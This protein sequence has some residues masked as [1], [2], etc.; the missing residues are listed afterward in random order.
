MLN[1]P[2]AGTYLK[3]DEKDFYVWSLMDGTHTIKQLVV[4]FFS[5][6]GT[7]AFGRVIDLVAQLRAASFLVDP[8]VNVYADV[9]RQCR[10][11]TV[12]YWGDRLWRSF[13]QKEMGFGGIDGI[14]TSLYRHVFWVFFARPSL[15]L[16]PVMFAAGL[17]LFLFTV[18]AGTYPLFHTAG[19]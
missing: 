6:Y 1:N 15:L 19:K 17:A 7:I 18:Q 11:G 10:K 5:E 8:Y 14:L 2:Q 9:D 13:L 12:S 3:L 4:A 16:Y